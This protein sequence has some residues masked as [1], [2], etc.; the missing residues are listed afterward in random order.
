MKKSNLIL[1]F[2][3]SVIV[4]LSSFGQTS[5]REIKINDDDGSLHLKFKND[6]VIKLRIDGR[7][8]SPSDYKNHQA[9][10][11][12]HREKSEDQS[13]TNREPANEKKDMQEVLE[14]NLRDYLSDNDIL[15]SY[16]Y[17]LKLT[18][19][20]VV[21]NGKRLSEGVLDNCLDIFE[22]TAGYSLTKGSC[23]EVKITSKSKSISLSI[24][25]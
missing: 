13:E 14:D 7:T 24:E 22:D 1:T 25:D 9:L 16:V 15:N 6:K 11:D 21:L 17:D 10:I 23:F 4:S 2:L 3:L 12:E 5:V 19:Q 8:I 18:S 20:K